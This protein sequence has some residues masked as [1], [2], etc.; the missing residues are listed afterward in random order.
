MTFS[1]QL[2]ASTICAAWDNSTVQT[3]SDATI[4]FTNGNPDSFTAT[5]ATCGGGNFGTVALGSSNYVSGT[6]TLSFTGSTVA[7]NPF[8]DTLTFTLGTRR[9]TG[10]VT[11]G[12]NVAAGTPAYTADS[13]MAD[14]SGNGASTTQISGSTSG[15]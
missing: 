12:T 1:E 6:G 9:T 10:L 11:I 2:D 14:L 3:V 15:L 4:T 13:N 7:W 5:S 8:N